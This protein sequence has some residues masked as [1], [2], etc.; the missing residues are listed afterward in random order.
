MKMKSVGKTNEASSRTERDREAEISALKKKVLL[1]E[2][3]R[4]TLVAQTQTTLLDMVRYR[5]E[6]ASRKQMEEELIRAKEK[7]EEASLTRDEFLANMSHEL[8]TPM[9]VFIGALEYLMEIDRIPEHRILLDMADQ[10][11]RRLHALIED[12]LDFSRIEANRIEITKEPFDLRFCIQKAVHVPAIQARKKNIDLTVTLDPQLPLACKG[13]DER[14]EQIL[15][16]LVGNAV[17]FT[18][19]GEV[20]LMVEFR[21]EEF[22]F[23]VHDT[24]IGV[25]PDKLDAIFT[26]F[27][28]VDSSRTRKYGGTGL[29]LAICKG[30]VELMGGEIKVQSRQGEG[31]VFSFTLP[32]VPV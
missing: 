1:L 17:K 21:G 24:G 10:A 3:E 19:Q 18:E 22:L 7:A 8:R 32:L 11:A 14:L 2:R 13:D 31:S 6:A 28:Q 15:V 29:G 26:S 4:D 16:N 23:S 20:K 9:T 27:S 30:L 5:A 12:I 25:P